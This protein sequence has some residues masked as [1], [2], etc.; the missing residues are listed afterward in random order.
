MLLR[1]QLVQAQVAAV[2]SDSNKGR[3][4]LSSRPGKNEAPNEDNTDGRIVLINTVNL[5]S[6]YMYKQVTL[7]NTARLMGLDP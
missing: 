4:R 7:Y 5:W 3:V 6:P 2:Q 1:K